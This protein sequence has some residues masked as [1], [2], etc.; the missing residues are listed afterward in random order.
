MKI[1]MATEDYDDRIVAL[2]EFKK[3]NAAH[4]VD[5]VT[6]GDELMEYLTSRAD[7]KGELP[8]LLLL[9]SNIHRKIGKDP[10][11][12]IK[13]NARF[14]QIDVV[15]FSTYSSL[16]EEVSNWKDGVMPLSKTSDP[17]E[18]IWIFREI[19]DCLMTKAGWH[20]Q[21]RPTTRNHEIIIDYKGPV[22][23]LN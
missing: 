6:S 3:L 17:D 21:I 19:C 8:D 22:T 2:L 23:S 11:W 5:F 1:L 9:N 4:A 15:V 20:Y 7:R 14:R 13:A 10:L 18:L 16:K 12:T